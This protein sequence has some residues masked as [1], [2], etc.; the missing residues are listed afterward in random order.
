MTTE[1]SR[2]GKTTQGQPGQL[3]ETLSHRLKGTGTQVGDGIL[4][5]LMQGSRFN[6]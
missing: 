1:N 2:G 6:I 3:H 5:W 4:A